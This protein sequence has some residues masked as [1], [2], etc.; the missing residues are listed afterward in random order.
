VIDAEEAWDEGAV[1]IATAATKTA[2]PKPAPA[3]KTAAPAKRPTLTDPGDSSVA[4]FDFLN[5]D[6]DIKKQPKL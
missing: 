4:D 1:P 3:P 5:E 2:P 6:D